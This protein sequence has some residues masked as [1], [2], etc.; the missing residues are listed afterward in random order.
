MSFGRGPDH[1]DPPTRN[2][3]NDLKERV[4]A[5]ESQLDRITWLLVMTLAATCADLA[6]S[7]MGR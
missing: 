4:R 7:L 6:R 2:E 3:H 1:L 5:V